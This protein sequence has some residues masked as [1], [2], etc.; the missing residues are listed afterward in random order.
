MPFKRP[1]QADLATFVAYVCTDEGAAVA[2]DVVDQSGGSGGAIHGGGLSGAAR[3]ST[4]SPV[5]HTIL[6]EI[7]NIPVDMACE[8]VTELCKTGANVIVLGTQ[9]DLQTYRALR[10][11]GATEYFNLPVSAADILTAQTPQRP[12]G[13]VVDMPLVKTKS[14]SIAVM[15]ATGGVGASVLAQNLAYHLSSPKGLNQR[16]ALL[17]ADLY[18]GSQ[19]IDLDRDSTAGLFEALMTPDRIDD[20]FISATMSHLSDQ[21]SLY[22]HQVGAG[23]DA[24]PYEGGLPRIFDPLRAEFEA[25]VTD[26]PRRLLFDRPDVTEHLDAVMLVIPAGFAGVNAATRLIERIHMSAPDL[27][28]LPVLSEL[29]QDAGLSRK[30]IETT[31]DMPLTAILPRSDKP[32]TKAHRAAKPL[33]ELQ[34]RGPY[35]KVIRTLWEATKTQL[36]P[37]AQ[38]ADAKADRPLRKRLFG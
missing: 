26:L 4:D 23:Q 24:G 9:S 31:L 12:S 20:T 14:P 25:V 7:G 8:C 11:A 35:A 19:A 5:A 33:V 32:L 1:P 10:T 21:L 13:V 29:R 37:A 28:I 15:G 18:F 17:D 30:D 36:K 38:K 27:R 34:P 6:A 2:R 22:S 3:L 16:T